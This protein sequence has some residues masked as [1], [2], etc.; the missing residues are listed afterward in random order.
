MSKTALVLCGG[1]G[2]RFRSISE[3]PK[4]LTPFGDALFIDWLL[5]YLISNNYKQIILS[6]GYR[7]KEIIG[8]LKSRDYG[9]NIDYVIEEE[10][11]GTGGAILNIFKLRQ[12]CE[13]TVFNGDTYWS[14][15]IPSAFNQSNKFDC[16]L[17]V[18]TLKHNNRYGNV[19][20][21]NDDTVDI[22]FPDLERPILNSQVY[23]GIA[24]IRLEN[25][26]FRIHR[27][28]SFETLICSMKLKCL[29]FQYSGDMCD[30][31]TVSGF[32]NLK[33]NY[34]V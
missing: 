8:Y 10:S 33:N 17:L 11:L 30:F 27:P 9:V 22:E 18:K 29:L 13:V 16:S 31:G 4:I 12:L 6:L 21:R 25:P 3:K 19:L 28:F 7:Y 26:I 2:T 32:Q 20:I 34:E 1:K 23:I 14:A 15:P 5:N 24:R